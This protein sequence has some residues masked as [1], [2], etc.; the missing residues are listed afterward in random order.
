MKR[1][2]RQ[3]IFD[4]IY[5]TKGEFMKLTLDDIYQYL[6][7]GGSL[8]LVS[9]HIL[10]NGQPLG[11]PQLPREILY[12]YF[13]NGKTLPREYPDIPQKTINRRA[14]KGYMDNVT[15]EQKLA[16]PDKE[17]NQYVENGGELSYLELEQ[18]PKIRQQAIDKRAANGYDLT[19]A[20]LPTGPYRWTISDDAINQYAE[21]GGNLLELQPEQLQK[22]QRE[23]VKKRAAK[24]YDLQNLSRE[25]KL[26]ISSTEI[27]QYVENGG[28]LS[29]LEP[30]QL[31]RIGQQAINKR[32][33]NGYELK[34]LLKYQ[35]SA[36]PK[37]AIDQR[38]INFRSLSKLSEEQKLAIPQESINERA[39]K[40]KSLSGLFVHQIG[41][42]PKQIR[43]ITEEGITALILYSV[44]KIKSN[45]LPA[46]VYLNPD[47][48]NQLLNII[49]KRMIAQYEQIC[50]KNGY[51]EKVP[52]KVKESFDGKLKEVEKS[53]EHKMQECLAEVNKQAS[54]VD[55]IGAMEGL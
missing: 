40:G 14:A 54:A 55:A 25:Q 41:S 9:D 48:R 4:I 7:K 18:L 43:E 49:R 47:L 42:I 17:L 21:N 32:A 31:P 38:V 1:L 52:D 30:E 29:D 11:I 33:A 8:S 6:A 50:Q 5:M 36:I 39:A 3:I 27:N 35:L 46:N 37:D 28:N 13:E 34:G 23:A 44:G 22:I 20:W 16:I 24:G 15:R 53:V 26:A 2:T 45:E 51:I 10:L 12:K 19:G